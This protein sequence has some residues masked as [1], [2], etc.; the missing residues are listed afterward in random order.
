M[1]FRFDGR[2]KAIDVEGFEC[3]EN[4]LREVMKA[5]VEVKAVLKL[6]LTQLCSGLTESIPPELNFLQIS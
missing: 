2:R 1:D 5:S 3:R 4:L 6:Q